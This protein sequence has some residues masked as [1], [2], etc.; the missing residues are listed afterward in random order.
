MTV[1]LIGWTEGRLR[2]VSIISVL[3]VIVV[4]IIIFDQLLTNVLLPPNADY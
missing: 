2:R 1:S 3:T 4:S